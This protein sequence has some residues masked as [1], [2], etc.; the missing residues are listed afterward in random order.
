[1][2]ARTILLAILAAVPSAV[3]QA[4][5]DSPATAT[6]RPPDGPVLIS[7]AVV[8]S[9]ADGKEV[10]ATRRYLVRFHR[11]GAGWRI[12]G[13][14]REVTVV[15][16][17]SLERF[18]ELERSRVEPGFFPIHLDSAGHLL[19]RNGPLP[20]DGARTKAVALAQ[21][22]IGGALG[23]PSARNQANA[24]LAQ[25]ALAGSGGTAWPVDLFSPA[26]DESLETRQITMP[27]GTRGSITVTIHGEGLVPGGLPQRVERTVL[28]D[29]GG[30]KRT[31][32]EIWTFERTQR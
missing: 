6:F 29:L 15:V 22:L 4:A 2:I 31:S 21:T 24:M 11:D 10:S 16:P 3:L 9:L 32:R 30:S 23:S 1:M 13:D 7:R 5:P 12:E 19:A 8:R 14:L 20:G 28:T 17:P 27:D 18:A 26:R 25:V